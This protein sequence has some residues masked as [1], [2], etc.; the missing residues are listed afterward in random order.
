MP[1]HDSLRAEATCTNGH[2]SSADLQFGY[3]SPAYRI[4]AVGDSIIW[5]AGDRLGD[6]GAK[7]VRALAYVVSVDGPSPDCPM[8]NAKYPEHAV[9]IAQDVIIGFHPC[10]ADELRDLL[11]GGDFIMDE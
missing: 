4:V 11:N 9:E 6:P 1:L 2:T 8:C 5:D 7:R 10:S 3:G